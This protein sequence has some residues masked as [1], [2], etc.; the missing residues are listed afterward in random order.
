MW[1]EAAPG[2]MGFDQ[3]TASE[4]FDKSFADIASLNC[5]TIRPSNLPLPYVDQLMASAV[6][7]G[8][9]VIL[10][11][12]W[13]HNLMRITP[14]DILRHWDSLKATIKSEV[15]DPYA[16]YENLLGYAVTDEPPPEKAEQWKLTVKMFNQLDPVHP[17]YTCFNNPGVLAGMVNDNGVPLANCVYDNY[18]HEKKVPLNTMGADPKYGWFNRYKLF[19]TACKGRPL[20]PQ[21]STVAVFKND[22]PWR[23]PTPTEFRTTV[24]TSLAA[25]AKGIMFFAYM[26]APEP[27]GMLRCLVDSKWRPRQPLYD[28]VKTVA[29]ELKELTPLLKDLQAINEVKGWGDSWQTLRRTFKS[30]ARRT[31]FILANKGPDPVHGYTD[32]YI[33]LP[34][35]TYW[36]EDIHT[37]EIFRANSRGVAKISLPPAYGRVLKEGGKLIGYFD[38]PADGSADV[39]GAIP[40]TGWALSSTGNV[41]V[42]IKRAPVEGD[43]GGIIDSDQ[44]VFI[45]NAVFVEGVRP[46]V[47][48]TFPDYPDNHKA[49]WGYMLLTNFLPKKGNGTFVLYAI[50]HDSQGNRSEL[51]RKTITCNN[52]MAAKPFG[53]I[54]TPAQGGTASGRHYYNWGWVLTPPPKWI[55][56]DGKTIRVRV[57]GKFIGHPVYGLR[58]KN[59]SIVKAFP[60]CLNNQEGR[61]AV[62]YIII[63]TKKYKDGLHR[64]EWSVKDSA[65]KEGGIG[66]RWFHIQNP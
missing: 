46:D 11:P 36:L 34:G 19:Y 24:Y 21:I 8:L 3:H 64:I 2:N 66:S 45:G 41:T 15:I 33:Q 44:L 25:G 55:P 42:E 23:W 38:T 6:A 57:D 4:F 31:Y 5:N 48:E 35:S 17:D 14:A 50:A 39:E 54:D 52:A 20:L 60:Q 61:G 40:V 13:G 18:P 58:R 49:G 62:G 37:S 1:L 53:T 29:A 32:G 16:G 30:P 28:T 27:G 59:E 56:Y 63:D 51:G 65:G 12:Q 26:D 10:D 9:K 47:A 43:P 22:N 7:H